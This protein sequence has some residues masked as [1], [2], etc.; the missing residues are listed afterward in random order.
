MNIYKDQ[1]EFTFQTVLE[2]AQWDGWRASLLQRSNKLLSFTAVK[3]IL[4]LGLAQDKGIQEIEI[5]DIVG[6]VGRY[7]EFTR[8][9]KPTHR[10]TRNRWKK[11]AE[12]YFQKGFDP[13]RVYKVSNIYFVINGN[14][15]VSISRAMK[16]QTISAHLFEFDTPLDLH[17]NDDLDSICHKLNAFHSSSAPIE[18]RKGQITNI[19]PVKMQKSRRA[20]FTL[21][22][23]A[24]LIGTVPIF[25]RFSEVGPMATGFWRLL[26]ALPFLLFWLKRQDQLSVGRQVI[27]RKNQLFWLVLAG[28][29][30]AGDQ[31]TFNLA[32]QKTTVANATLLINM[33]PVFVTLA[34]WLLFKERIA[35][36]FMLGLALAMIGAL[37]L[38]GGGANI[39]NESLTGDLFGLLSAVFSAMYTISLTKVRT[40][41]PVSIVMVLVAAVSS[42]LLLLLGGIS[43]EKLIAPTISS[44]L[45]LLALALI[46]HIGGQG[47]ITL[48]VG[49]LSASTASIG[50]LI[51]PIAAAIMAAV[52]LLEPINIGQIIGGTIILAGISLTQAGDD[53]KKHLQPGRFTTRR[54]S[55]F[56]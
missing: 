8:T 19:G 34:V 29:G 52:I 32:V 25:V 10:F 36:T 5:D 56:A 11:V 31:A 44:W 26:L 55:A 9:F 13:I 16:L 22:L 35:L 54:Q 48:S 17:K 33:A 3:N 27:T 43:G 42:L 7:N 14:H 41:L 37:V 39:T 20:L 51:Q 12:S 23:G 38:V 47:L 6:S 2:E 28:I 1:A 4:R 46:S 18:L 40:H 24:V 30:F 53:L 15:R 49:R 45:P 50:L 21:M